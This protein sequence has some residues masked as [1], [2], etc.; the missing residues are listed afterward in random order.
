LVNLEELWLGKNKIAKLEVNPF[1]LAC[2]ALIS[3]SMVSFL[4]F[5]SIETAQDLGSAFKPHHQD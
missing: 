5:R 3:A 1:T 4:E 2:P